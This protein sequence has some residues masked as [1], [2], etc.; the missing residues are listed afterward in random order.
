MYSGNTQHSDDGNARC[1][2]HCPWHCNVQKRPHQP[3]LVALAFIGPHILSATNG[4]GP[5]FA[6]F[7]KSISYV[8]PPE[9]AA[10]VAVVVV[11]VV[12]ANAVIESP[13]IVVLLCVVPSST[14]SFPTALPTPSSSFPPLQHRPLL[15]GI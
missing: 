4:G 12:V 7:A 11:V 14:L 6:H 9:D 13:I 2:R 10:I 8:A 5:A 1:P 3:P 15:G